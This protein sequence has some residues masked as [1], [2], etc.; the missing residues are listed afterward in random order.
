MKNFRSLRMLGIAQILAVTFVLSTVSL[1]AAS[2]KGIVTIPAPVMQAKQ[3][4]ELHNETGLE[5]TNVYL[6]ET[7]KTNWEEDVLG[8][9]TLESGDSVN[10]TFSGQK[11]NIWD[12]KVVFSN[13]KEDFWL[14]L[15]LSQLT[16]ITI[17]F[18]NGKT[19][20]TTKNGD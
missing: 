1:P 15:N 17:S 7:G 13:G 9:D 11:A 14:K 4:F 20:A 8:Q 19:W 2:A 5:I 12:M 6:S 10:I 3:D 18:K 16:D